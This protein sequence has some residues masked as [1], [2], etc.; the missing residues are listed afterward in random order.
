MDDLPRPDDEAG[1][2]DAEAADRLITTGEGS[3][4]AATESQ[5][6]FVHPSVELPDWVP[7]VFGLILIG[8]AAAAIWM[9]A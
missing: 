8:I 4:A 1:P 7:V 2:G 3:V 9:A 6:D 5:E